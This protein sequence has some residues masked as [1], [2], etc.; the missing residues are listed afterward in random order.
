M[1]LF[2][3]GI[4]TGVGKTVAT[5]LL[6]R[7]YRERGVSVITQKLV[8]TGGVGISE[9]IRE[10]RRLMG[11][12][13]LPEDRAGLTCPAVYPL[14]ASPHL[15]AEQAGRGLDG[16]RLAASARELATRYEMVLV[17]GAGGLCVPL[18]RTLLT[19]DW[20][21]RQGWPVVLVT[22]PRLGSINHT[23]LSL[24]ALRT[25][26]MALAAVLYNRHEP[27]L[28]AIAADTRRVIA[29]ALAQAEPPVPLSDFGDP[30][31]GIRDCDWCIPD[32]RRGPA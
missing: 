25:R 11:V 19:V 9:D 24:E 13:L 7:A 4:D 12:P 6:A 26:G 29:D 28:P 1:I 8:Q 2:V 22:S 16:E 5:G 23:L 14:P 18:T 31:E 32:R 17:E 30:N 3:S 10:H 15:A 27:V 21:A 20:V